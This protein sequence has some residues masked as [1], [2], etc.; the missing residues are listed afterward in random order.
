VSDIV[1]MNLAT[2]ALIVV[3]IVALVFSLAES[4]K[5]KAAKVAYF[6]SKYG[7]SVDRMLAECPA[8]RD[9]LR[10]I[11]DGGRDGVPKAVRELLHSDPIPVKPAAEFIKRI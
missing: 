1:W 2:V 10:V 6:E 9:Q 7:S 3:L 11:R 8:D 4:T 5:L